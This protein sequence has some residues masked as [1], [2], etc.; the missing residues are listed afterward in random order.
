MKRSIILFSL[1]LF[2]TTGSAFGQNVKVIKPVLNPKLQKI[3]KRKAELEKIEF[4]WDYSPVVDGPICVGVRIK[5]TGFRPAPAFKVSLRFGGS[6]NL[7]YKDVQSLAIGESQPRQ[8]CI[9]TPLKA[10][11]YQMKF[12]IDALNNV[13]EENE[14]NNEIIHTV[15][16]KLAK[17]NVQQFMFDPMYQ[18]WRLRIQNDDNP[19]AMNFKVTMHPANQPPQLVGHTESFSLS[20]GASK[21]IRAN[22]FVPIGQKMRAVIRTLP[23]ETIIKTVEVTKN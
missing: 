14:N 21:N 8:F 15:E 17:V 23:S 1:L 10:Q 5:N 2:L 4:L 7:I 3:L 19:S 18:V 13:K 16:V 22:L 11:K 6:L 12:H 9:L 20:S